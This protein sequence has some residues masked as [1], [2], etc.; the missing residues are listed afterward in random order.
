MFGKV[1]LTLSIA[2][3]AGAAQA[4]ELPF[5]ANDLAMLLPLNEAGEPLFKVRAGDPNLK[6]LSE[7][8]FNEV[9]AEAGRRHVFLNDKVRDPKNWYLVGVRYNPCEIFAGDVKPCKEQIRFVFQSHNNVRESGGF[10]D[11]AIHVV[12]V[13]NEGKSPELSPRLESFR[14]LKNAFGKQTAGRTL[15]VHPVL[16][17]AAGAQYFKML[18]EEVIAKHV[19]NRHA[20]LLTFMGIGMGDSNSGERDDDDWRFMKGDVDASGS[21]KATSL[22]TGHKESMQ[23]MSLSEEEMDLITNLKPISGQP[24]LFGNGSRSV[25]KE[26]SLIIEARKTNDH[27]VDCASCHI[28]D[29]MGYPPGREYEPAEK[30]KLV[31][32]TMGLLKSRARVSEV[33]VNDELQTGRQGYEVPLP[34]IFGYLD[35]KAAIALRMSVDNSTATEAANKLLKLEEK[36][37]CAS[38]AQRKA[39]IECVFF[40]YG[41]DGNADKC[42]KKICR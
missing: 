9:I 10:D 19:S 28:A 39:V 13:Y 30:A 41:Q 23:R 14:A 42:I 5:S 24:F 1:L 4:S 17:S 8:N 16:K 31:R 7:Q 32:M 12:Y 29:R 2:L 3:A 34:R 27:N 6:I 18:S 33:L 21:W 40:G 20:T 26:V 36:P 22:P 38:D 15:Q 35:A 25:D 37:Q 11:Y